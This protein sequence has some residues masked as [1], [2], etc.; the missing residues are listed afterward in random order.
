MDNNN[1]KFIIE[2]NKDEFQFGK[3]KSKIDIKF[4]RVAFI[5][6]VFFVIS[7]I[8]SIHLIHLGS[9]KSDI[10][11]SNKYN[12]NNPIK[13]ADI[14][15]INGTFLAKT[16]SSIDIGI[17]PAE[18]IN[19]KKL[20]I[21]LRYIFPNKNYDLVKSN[22]KKNKFFWF[23]KKISEENYEKLMKLG[24]KSI[25]S[26]EKIIRLY[27]QKNLFSHIIGQIDEDNNGISGLEKSFDEEL[28][29]NDKPLQLSVDKDIQFLIREELLKYNEIFK[30]L[31]SA[32][33]LMNVNN[34]EIISIV[35][36][37]D[38]NPNQRNA[39][40]DVNY[41]NRTTKGVYEL[42]SVFK[43]FTLA[44]AINERTVEPETEFKN[45]K[46]SVRCG[47]NIISEYDNKIPSNLTA[48]QI[49]IRSGNIGSVRIG[50][51]VG[52]N[53]YKK[54]LND[55]NL[56]NPI[57][58]DIEEVGIPVSFNWGKCKL[59]TV[60][61]GHGITTTILQLANAYSIIANGGY[62][63]YPTLINND[64][65]LKRERL[66]KK[67]VSNKINSILRKIVTSKEGTAS[68]ANVEGYE[69]GGKT[70]T[71]QKS[72]I[73]GYSKDK[74]NTFV[75]I[76][77][78]SNPKY[79]LVVMLDE[80]KINSEYIYHYRDGSGIKYKGTPFNTA[81]WTSVEVVGQII[82]KIGP[83]LATKYKEIN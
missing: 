44:A 47:K 49:L 13:R 14:I 56:I 83:I 2:E 4:K 1:S 78:I 63:I 39:I 70:G 52:I 22:I 58:F 82:E 55:L 50:Q 48:E 8:Y 11:I 41:I 36:L 45:L 12:I 3:S 25:K 61:Y 37:P 9:R 79:S 18:I 67:D 77:P 19:Q 42:G 72:A 20:L 46:K 73:G 69:V 54:F 26:E 24:D 38:F 80:P 35:S 32:A 7:L 27:P 28:K 30:T 6:F 53:D 43:T 23:E 65:N 71:A 15:D 74:I 16:V 29:N 68:L 51:S 21:N 75:S 81:G 33:I 66:L 76:F 34:G 17:N 31:G 62:Q 59:A 5:F 10:K 40:T 64:K 60:S 57:N